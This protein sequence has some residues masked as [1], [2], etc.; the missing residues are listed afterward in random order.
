MSSRRQALNQYLSTGQEAAGC[1]VKIG[2]QGD[3]PYS[4]LIYNPD[5]PKD[6]NSLDS[7]KTF[8]PNH[9]SQLPRS[10]VAVGNINTS[11]VAANA[12]PISAQN[13]SRSVGWTSAPLPSM[14]GERLKPCLCCSACTFQQQ[15][16]H[17][18]HLTDSDRIGSNTIGPR[19][20]YNNR[21]HSPT[22]S[23][24][25]LYHW[26]THGGIQYGKTKRNIKLNATFGHFTRSD[27]HGS[28]SIGP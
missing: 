1:H 7:F 10:A 12:N 5:R 6:P 24:P 18:G 3:Q 4:V 17:F 16:A 25:Q 9:L 14:N 21:C 27:R 13:H 15:N 28:E 19:G 2:G 8:M 26:N 20:I 22:N 23:M 11:L